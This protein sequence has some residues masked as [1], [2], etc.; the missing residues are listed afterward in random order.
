IKAIHVQVN[1][2]ARPGLSFHISNLPASLAC[3]ESDPPS[4]CLGRPNFSN[5][6]AGASE[7]GPAIK[8]MDKHM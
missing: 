8:Y 3:G 7:S 2:D 6:V 4:V 5:G 1:D